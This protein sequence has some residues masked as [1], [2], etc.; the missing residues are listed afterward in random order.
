MNDLAYDLLRKDR[1][2]IQVI[3]EWL[4]LDRKHNEIVSCLSEEK[5][6]EF[7]HQTINESKQNDEGWNVTIC[8]V[9]MKYEHE[10]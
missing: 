6:E 7:A 4:V 3:T 1:N 10:G 8:A 5:A 9:T 2:T